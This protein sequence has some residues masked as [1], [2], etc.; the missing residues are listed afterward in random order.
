MPP[1]KAVYPKPSNCGICDL[2]Q[3]GNVPT[4]VDVQDGIMGFGS[5]LILVHSQPQSEG[6]W[7]PS[8][9]PDPGSLR[10]AAVPMGGWAVLMGRQRAALAAQAALWLQPLLCDSSLGPRQRGK[11][12]GTQPTQWQQGSVSL[13]DISA[14]CLYCWCVTAVR[15][16]QKDKEEALYF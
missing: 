6:L 8:H 5:Q 3:Y 12:E 9:G 4:S 7:F 2:K 11:R 14:D 15:K 10:E 1:F 13:K 16:G